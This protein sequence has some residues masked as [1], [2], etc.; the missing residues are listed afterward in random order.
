MRGAK[1]KACRGATDGNR[2][3]SPFLFPHFLLPF[4]FQMQA[5]VEQQEQ[6]AARRAHSGAQGVERAYSFR[7][8]SAY[9]LKKRLL[10]RAADL[11]FFI[12][13]KLIGRTM[14]FEVEGW[15]H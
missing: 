9:P 4:A 14:R 15:E 12:L 7:D 1:S 10:I 6:A 2:Y 8:L 3:P 11:L 13:I 5:S